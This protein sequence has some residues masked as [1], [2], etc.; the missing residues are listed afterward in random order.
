MPAARCPL[1]PATGHCRADGCRATR[2]NPWGARL[3]QLVLVGNTM[4]SYAKI[5]RRHRA[6]LRIEKAFVLAIGLIAAATLQPLL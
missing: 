3:V 2:R 5:L 4:S 6:A 1:D